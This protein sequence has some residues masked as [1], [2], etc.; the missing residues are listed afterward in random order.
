[1]PIADDVL[2]MDALKRVQH[3][4]N[5]R[6][7]AFIPFLASVEQP[8]FAAMGYGALNGGKRLRP[9]F[10]WA[11]GK[12]YDLPEALL[13]DLGCCVEVIHAYSLIHDDLPCMDDAATRRGM[14]ACHKQYGEAI[15]LLAGSALQNSVFEFLARDIEDLGEGQ[16]LALITSLGEAIGTRGL[17]AGQAADLI[18][19]AAGAPITLAE[20]DRINAMKTGALYAW[21]AHAVCVAANTP[22]SSVKSLTSFAYAF[23]NFFQIVDDLLDAEGDDA[24]V[25]KPTHADLNKQNTVTILGVEGARESASTKYDALLAQAAAF[26][27]PLPKELIHF[28]AGQID[29]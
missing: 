25:G 17:I 27:S 15:A 21:C 29:L 5:Q 20:I 4:I 9:F 1:M 26:K 10:L 16:R 12:E 3:E 14:P 28:V 24:K 13:F 8:L 19:E 18:V 23:S 11:L 7:P 6:L 2:F 22:A